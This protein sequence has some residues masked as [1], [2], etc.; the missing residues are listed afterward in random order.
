MRLLALART[1]SLAFIWLDF[2]FACFRLLSLADLMSFASARSRSLFLALACSLPLAFILLS[3]FA[4]SFLWNFEINTFRENRL[5]FN[6]KR[7]FEA[8]GFHSRAR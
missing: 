4:H 6:L 8:V 5:V 7:L 1:R 3:A 2:V